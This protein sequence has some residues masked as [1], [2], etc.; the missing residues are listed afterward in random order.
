MACTAVHGVG[1]C[2]AGCLPDFQMPRESR[3][4][5]AAAC[6]DAEL[7]KNVICCGKCI[8][9]ACN[10]IEKKHLRACC[11]AARPNALMCAVLSALY[12]FN[13]SWQPLLAVST[14]HL[15]TMYD[16]CVHVCG[17]ARVCVV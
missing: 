12:C 17:C 10:I 13:V 15:C 11:V 2:L 5:S 4:S 14:H 1:G 9:G 3:F 8:I 6:D 16:I 7:N